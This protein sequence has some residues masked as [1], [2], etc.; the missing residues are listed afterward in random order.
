MR[1]GGSG[2]KSKLTVEVLRIGEEKSAFIG[3]SPG[4]AEVF[5]S[6]AVA[7]YRFYFELLG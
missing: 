7:F 6:C 1:D 4:P 3:E 5:W 2:K